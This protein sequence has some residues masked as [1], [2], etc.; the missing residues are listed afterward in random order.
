MQLDATAFFNN[1]SDLII[2]GRAFSGSSRYRTDNISNARARGGELG[3]AW[4]L[5][6]AWT[7]APPIR[8]STARS[9]LLTA[10]RPRPPYAVGDPCC[11]GRDTPGS[12]DALAGPRARRRFRS[13]PGPRRNAR[14]R[15]V[16]WSERGL[17]HESRG[18]TIVN[19][20]GRRPFNAL[21]VFARGANLFDRDY[22]E[23]WLPGPRYCD[24]GVRA[25]A[26]R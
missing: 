3:A 6:R 5:G 12:I 10:R 13:S 23:A 18:F 2:V 24:R 7:C 14:C 1:Y 25:A 15:S 9:S 11:G 16:V 22:E 19:L 26:G 17:F 21:E 8:S 4:R 20:G